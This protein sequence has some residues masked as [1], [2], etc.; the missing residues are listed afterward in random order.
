MK[1]LLLL[2]MVASVGA[3]NA[4]TLFDQS[5]YSTNAYFSDGVAGQFY[6]YRAAEGFTLATDAEIKSIEWWGCSENYQFPDLTNFSDFVVTIFGSP[7]PSAPLWS[8]TFSKAATN[9]VDTGVLSVANSNIFHQT[10]DGLSINLSAGSYYLHVGAVAI[11]P[12]DDGWAWS[13]TVSVYDDAHQQETGFGS[14]AWSSATDDLAAKISGNPV[15]E[16]GTFLAI[17][18]GVAALAA[19]RRRK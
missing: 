6:N 4:V 5:D 17:G 12:G 10:V 8:Q 15:P 13:D 18:V 2:A 9:P 14:G 19:F 16:P 7:L 11:S 1:K 3:A